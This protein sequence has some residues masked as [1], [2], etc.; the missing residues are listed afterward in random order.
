MKTDPMFKNF[1]TTISPASNSLIS[2]LDLEKVIGI[3]KKSGVVFFSGFDVDTD[4]FHQFTSLFGTDYMKYVGGAHKRETINKDGDQTILSVNFYLGS[5][6]QQGFELPLH[7]EM[8]YTKSRPTLI[9]FYCV[10]PAAEE[11]ETT[12]CDGAQVYQEL[13]DNTINLF[14][15]KR[16]KYVRYYP[17]GI[18]QERFQTEDL[19][20]VKQFC[21]ESDLN[22]KIDRDTKAI[23]TE[24]IYPAILK[25]RWGELDVF[26]NSIL[27][28]AW[29]EENGGKDSLIRLEDD[30]KIPNEVMQELKQVTSRLIRPI[31]WQKGDVVMIDNTRVLHGRKAFS[32]LQREVYT[33]MCKSVDW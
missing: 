32:D 14:K 1:G 2:E 8:F 13:S 26:L 6:K 10:M 7:G 20:V 9:W 22:L 19:G 3:F 18:W 15:K 16:L 12:V 30:S 5:S 4:K 27:I 33:R 24:Y 21:E 17:N 11:G 25:S 23:T 28:V 31:P 29:Q